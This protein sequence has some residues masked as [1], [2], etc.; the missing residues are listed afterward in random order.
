MPHEALRT[1]EVVIIPKIDIELEMGHV[2]REVGGI[3][4]NDT[5]NGSPPDFENAD[6]V[7]HGDKLVV[8]LKCLTE[9][10]VFSKN[11]EEKSANL[12]RRCYAKGLVESP[13]VNDRDWRALPPQ[14]QNK[15][16]EIKTRSIKKRVQK[17][18]RQ[19]RET[20]ER[21][22]LS[23]YAGVL[24]IANDGVRSLTPPACIHAI[25]LALRNDH[26]EIRHFVFFTANLLSELRQTPSQ[27][28]F[29]ISFDM[30]DGRPINHAFLNYLGNAWR[31]RC[32]E[33]TGIGSFEEEL[34]D[35]EGFWRSKY[36]PPQGR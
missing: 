1:R 25:Q 8:E 33:I 17:A 21:L 15:F 31:A 36:V 12:W 9:D 7:F 11:N 22:G 32:S 28:L 2:V 34:V 23:D 20:K 6:F 30:E 16:Y 19:V 3:V 29:W 35:V 18:N 26:R 14:I 4:L 27:T 5:F 13:R 10:N 24:F